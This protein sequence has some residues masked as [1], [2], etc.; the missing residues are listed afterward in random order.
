MQVDCAVKLSIASLV[1][2]AT[3]SSKATAI[4]TENT[5]TISAISALAFTVTR[6]NEERFQSEMRYQVIIAILN[7]MLHEGVITQTDH[8]AA[9]ER[10]RAEYEP[11]FLE[12]RWKNDLINYPDR[13]NMPHEQEGRDGTENHSDR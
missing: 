2:D 13:A 4:S 9:E 7:E 12:K 1:R 8:S 10:M 3:E 6:M 5:A 11:I